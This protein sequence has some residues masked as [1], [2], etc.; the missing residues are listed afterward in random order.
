M[1]WSNE[2]SVKKKYLKKQASKEGDDTET[3]MLKSAKILERMVNLNTYDDIA[4]DFRFWEDQSDE[5]KDTE[6]S[7]LPLWRFNL[8]SEVGCEDLEVTGLCWN[9]VY[10]DLFAVSYGSY[11]F[12][13]QPSVGY[14]CL[15]S[16][17]NPSFPEWLCSTVSGVMTV[18]LH[19]NHPHMVVCGQE[20]F[21]KHIFLFENVFFA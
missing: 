2:K 6:G 20:L 1:L 13:K 17:K 8:S 21:I 7:L 5:F 18:D 3:R 11:D 12:Y 15:Y 10:S 14:L 4:Q 16:L 9:P 19:P